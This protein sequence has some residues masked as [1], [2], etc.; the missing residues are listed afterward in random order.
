MTLTPWQAQVYSR[1]VRA[2]AAR[3]DQVGLL[4][5]SEELGDAREAVERIRN[6]V[7]DLKV[8][9]RSPDDRTTVTPDSDPSGIALQETVTVNVSTAIRP[10]L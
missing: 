3:T 5:I 6:I 1:A 8:F 2:L 7:R 10:S 4:E 9:S